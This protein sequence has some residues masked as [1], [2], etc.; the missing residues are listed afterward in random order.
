MLKQ[1]RNEC[2]ANSLTEDATAACTLFGVQRENKR[3][4]THNSRSEMRQK[5]KE[6]TAIA[7]EI[8]S[9]KVRVLRPVQFDELVF[10]EYGEDSIGAVVSLLRDSGFDEPVRQRHSTLARGIHEDKD[11]EDD[12]EA[13]GAFS[14]QCNETCIEHDADMDADA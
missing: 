13:Q 6:R 3:R 7:I 5:R 4:R 9:V 14:T 10:V 8:N 11:A 12:V 1:I 2:Q